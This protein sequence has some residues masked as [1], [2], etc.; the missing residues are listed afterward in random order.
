MSNNQNQNNINDEWEFESIDNNYL[1]TD[2]DT[3][4]H[5]NDFYEEDEISNTKYNIVLCEIFHHLIHGET[6]TSEL[7]TQYLIISTF[8]SLNMRLINYMRKMHYEG[9]R[10]RTQLHLHKHSYI[11]NYQYIL[12]QENYIKPEIAETIYLE[13]GHSVCIIKTI[14]LKLIQRTWKKI[15]K[16]RKNMIRQRCSIEALNYRKIVGNWP[17]SCRHIPDL[18]GMLYLS[19]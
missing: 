15:Y 13:S 3:D 4:E 10:L 7:N 11:R 8:K 9:C 2:D 19:R 16:I 6:N 5:E 17:E 18:K 1:D 12:S 14:W